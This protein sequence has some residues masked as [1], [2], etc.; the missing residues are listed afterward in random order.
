MQDN[1]EASIHVQA[2]VPWVEN[3]NN[4]CTRRFDETD[5]CF[6]QWAS[7]GTGPYSVGGGSFFLTWR[8]SV[9]WDNDADLFFLS[10]AG[11]G[12]SGFYPG[13][14]QRTPAPN[15]W[16]SSIVKMQTSN[17]TGTVTLRSKDPR[18]AP[19]INFNFFKEGSEADLQALAEGV[20]LLRRVYDD[21]GV[22]YKMLAPNPEVELKQAIMDEAF[23][24]H[25]TSS[26]RMGPAGDKDYCVDSKFRVNGVKNLRVVDASVFPR[27]PGAMPNGPTFTIS[28]KA[29]KAI[30]EDR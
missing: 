8:S 14:S 20:E 22:P 24:H 1:Y 19:E 10:V 9:S 27:V 15:M 29:F 16:A 5:P 25:A 23:S 3:T 12:D 26:C 11:V 2:E 13:F 6:V 18:Q 17:P 30:L 28:R 4:P 21:A 7:N